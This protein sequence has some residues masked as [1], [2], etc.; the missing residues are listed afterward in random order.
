MKGKDLKEII[1]KLPDDPEVVV[2]QPFVIDR[3]DEITAILDFPIT[4]IAVNDQSEEK[5]IRFILGMDDVK[6]C[7]KAEHI[8]FLDESLKAKLKKDK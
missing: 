2:A 4:G 6:E 5:E 1:N 8:Y 7:F 3:Q